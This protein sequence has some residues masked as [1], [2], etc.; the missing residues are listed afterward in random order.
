[1]DYSGNRSWG[2]LRP[3]AQDRLRECPPYGIYMLAS[4]LRQAGHEVVV[5]DLIALGSHSIRLY[6]H[7]IADCSLIGIG[8]TSLSWPTASSVIRQI[9]R[10]RPDVPIVLGGIHPTLFD[11][12]LLRNFP[13]QYIV[14]GEGEIALTKLCEC[15]ETGGDLRI[16]PNLSWRRTDG[17]VIRNAVAP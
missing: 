1:M 13:V 3:I 17:Q 7:H 6:A 9:R 2:R 10:M 16:V 12:Y 14:R 4:I 8:S 15:L 11:L 5:A